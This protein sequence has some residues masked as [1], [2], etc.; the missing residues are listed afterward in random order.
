MAEWMRPWLLVFL[1]GCVVTLVI[2]KNIRLQQTRARQTKL[3]ADVEKRTMLIQKEIGNVQSTLEDLTSIYSMYP[4]INRDQFTELTS[5]ILARDRSF[6]AIG[7]N[8]IIRNEDRHAF[9]ETA[10][11][12]FGFPG[13]SINERSN[14]G[15][16]KIADQRSEYVVVLFIEPLQD[17][18]TAIGFDIASEPIRRNAIESARL[19]KEI[20]VTAPINLVQDSTEQKS[21]LVCA[22]CYRSA[23][24]L[25]GAIRQEPE[26]TGFVVGV[27]RLRNLISDAIGHLDESAFDLEIVDTTKRDSPQSLGIGTVASDDDV[28]F[29]DIR[30]GARRWQLNFSAMPNQQLSSQTWPT[31]KIYGIGVLLTIVVSAFVFAMSELSIRR[32]ANRILQDDE[33]R[34]RLTL[35]SVADGWWDYDVGSGNYCYSE[36]WPVELSRANNEDAQGIDVIATL[37]S[38]PEVRRRKSLIERCLNR[39]LEEYCFEFQLEGSDGNPRWMMERGR[40]VSWHSDGHATRMVGTIVDLT[41]QKN[42]ELQRVEFEAKF[43]ESQKLE[44]LGLLAGGIA[45]D[46]NN[47]LASIMGNADLAELCVDDPHQRNGALQEI[48]NAT[49]SASRLTSQMLAYAGKGKVQNEIIDLGQVVNDMLVLLRTGIPCNV[50]IDYEPAVAATMEGD[51]SQVAQVVMNLITNAVDALGS[52]GGNILIA[53]ELIRVDGRNRPIEGIEYGEYAMLQVAD[54]GCGMSQEVAARIFEPFF[55]TKEK[56]HGLGLAAVNGI[57]R[58]HDGFINLESTENH[59]TK[60]TVYFRYAAAS[61]APPVVNQS[62]KST[63]PVGKILVVDD[64]QAVRECIS[65]LLQMKGYE[66]LAADS[67]PRG[68]ELFEQHK[69]EID[70]SLIDMTM[71]VLN[72]LETF[73]QLRRIDG[74]AKCLI[75]SGY[76]AESVSANS[77]A[78]G[79]LGFLHKPFRAKYLVRDIE[80]ALQRCT[81]VG[82]AS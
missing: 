82:Q 31:W 32:S 47:Y 79:I 33:E 24:R 62:V 53:L 77:V 57:I 48:R 52:D 25:G 42:A 11:T 27:L 15:G 55:T 39:E 70:L 3:N 65:Q 4:D 36:I 45:H 23:I 59:G 76:S 35:N 5:P 2:G 73:E 61:Y 17:N 18:E 21:V 10:K 80:Q 8:P 67:G 26:L 14:S 9:E 40:V 81:N 16:L 74:H 71:P 6:S 58:R 46:F 78:N 29:R 1:L 44:S 56:G 60:I 43:R 22:P 12:R 49:D 20:S 7:W 30:W 41:L 63:S 50:A 38:E 37:C 28:L 75:M 13:F 69:D 66:T 34:L 54:D 19:S 68:V 72:G 64:E 51:R